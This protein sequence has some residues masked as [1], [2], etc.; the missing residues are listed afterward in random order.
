MSASYLPGTMSR[1]L[2]SAWLGDSAPEQLGASAPCYGMT[3]PTCVC[4]L[5]CKLCR[6]SPGYTV[7]DSA[8]DS[9]GAWDFVCNSCADEPDGLTRMGVSPSL[10]NDVPRVVSPPHVDVFVESDQP[11][12]FDEEYDGTYADLWVESLAG[13]RRPLD[14]KYSV[15]HPFESGP[16][17]G[18]VLKPLPGCGPSFCAH[19]KLR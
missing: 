3:R 19:A 14:R 5:R 8:E 7:H 10:V 4:Q 13:M 1:S 12:I 15:E 2:A 11:Y 6:S 18:V 17:L 16:L 9:P